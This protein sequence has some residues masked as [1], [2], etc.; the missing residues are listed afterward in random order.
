MSEVFIH[1][2]AD[3][4]QDARVADG[5]KIWSYAQIREGAQV[6]A[7]CVI[8]KN[9]Y[10]DFGVHIG[11]RV[12]IQNNVS[13]YHGVT[14]EDG[15]FVGPHVCFTNDLLPRA[16]TPDGQLKGTDDWEV[17]PIV[18]R[19]GASLGANSTI[20]PGVTIGSFALVGAGAVVSRDVPDHGLVYGNPARL[21][22]YVCR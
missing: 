21:H 20:V 13:V 7:E 11:N 8:G 4:S 5:T 18:V 22:G 9:V 15:V 19:Y 14:I 12:K 6:G 16:I 2:T 17:G 1:P 10:V 3:V